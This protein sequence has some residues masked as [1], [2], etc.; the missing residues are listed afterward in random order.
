MVDAL[1]AGDGMIRRFMF[2]SYFL[3]GLYSFI[4]EYICF[5][6]GPIEGVL[7]DYFDTPERYMHPW[8][9]TLVAVR[10]V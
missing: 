7:E 10:P 3:S 4:R 9:L 5:S 2:R 8:S 1:S 6:T